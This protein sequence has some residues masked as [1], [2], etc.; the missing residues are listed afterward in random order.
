[1]NNRFDTLCICPI[2]SKKAPNEGIIPDNSRSI[3]WGNKEGG[4][5]PLT[6]AILNGWAVLTGASPCPKL[7]TPFG[8]INAL[9]GQNKLA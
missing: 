9:K 3:I 6:G 5:E 4:Y 1:M 8:G 7:Y 2:I